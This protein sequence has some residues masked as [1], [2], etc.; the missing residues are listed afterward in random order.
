MSDANSSG[1]RTLDDVEVSGKA[2]LVRVDFNVPMNDKGAIT[3]DR[4]IAAAIPTLQKI[5]DGGGKLVLASHLGRPAGT[6]YEPG[7]SLKCVAVRLQELLG[8]KV[9]FPSNDCI[10]ET[11]ANAVGNLNI[12][13]VLLLENTRFHSEEKKGDPEFAQRLASYG[14]IFCNDAFGATHRSDATMVAL[15]EC[16]RPRPCVAGLLLAKEIHWLG[17]VVNSADRP[18]VA[19]LGGAKISD[20]LGTL[21]HLAGKVDA[22]LVGGAM[23]F[24]LLKALGH[25]TG[26]SLLEDGMVEEAG[27]IIADV[28]KTTTRLILPSDFVC[29][30]EP[31]SQTHTR[32]SGQ[33]IPDG[34]MGLDIGPQ[35][36][37]QFT[38]EIRLARTI[39]WNGPMGLFEVSPFDVGTR[40]VAEAIGIATGTG[41]ASIAG[42]GDTAAAV[43]ACGL[44]DRFSHIST[45][46]GASLQMLEGR[47]L[48]GLEVLDHEN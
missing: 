24:T 3:D 11:A 10:D 9:H 20:K 46:G 22:L 28:E 4:R 37:A 13:E 36:T 38:S 39:V 14:E 41:A 47:P 31:S 40:E 29:G 16:M 33:D 42:G 25:S 1:F 19:I 35:T 6:G 30:E 21:R 43:H 27:R 26:K 34:M 23:A 48:P 5:L 45:G 2:V 17:E 7:L 8:R 15:P 12:G 44:E 32:V 18:F